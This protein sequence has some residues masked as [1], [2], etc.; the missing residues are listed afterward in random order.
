MRPDVI[1]Q[2]TADNRLIV[3]RYNRCEKMFEDWCCGEPEGIPRTRRTRMVRKLGWVSV[4]AAENRYSA[5]ESG[6]ASACVSVSV[7]L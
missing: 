1:K 4:A 5:D 7:L 3:T 2:K 6:D